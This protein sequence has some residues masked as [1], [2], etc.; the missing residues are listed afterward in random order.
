MKLEITEKKDNK[1][2]GR[3]E[4][5]GKLTFEGVTPSNKTLQDLLAV[6]LKVDKKLIVVKQ[7][8][9]MFSYQEA[10]FLA[11]VYTDKE[12]MNKMEVMTKHLRKKEEEKKKKEAEAAKKAEEEKAAVLEEKTEKETPTKETKPEGEE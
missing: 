6:E 4:V 3:I 2:L 10:E 5:N 11:Y 8:K 7:I 12:K 1:L 9:G